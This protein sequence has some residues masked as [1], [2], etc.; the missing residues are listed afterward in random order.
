MAKAIAT[1]FEQEKNPIQLIKIKELDEV[2]E[3]ATDKA[4][5]AAD[6]LESIVLKSA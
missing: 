2:L 6:V 5:D 3:Y 1:L 4:D